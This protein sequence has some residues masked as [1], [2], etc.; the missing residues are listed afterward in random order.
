MTPSPR[1]DRTSR[2]QVAGL[3]LCV[4]CAAVAALPA[5]AHAAPPANDAFADAQ[6]VRV[7]DR[8]TG[9]TTDA[10]LQA[11]EPATGASYTR[12]VWYRLTPTTSEMLRI[13][14][15][16]GGPWAEL[17]VFTGTGVA[18]L[19]EVTPVRH[20][21]S[22]GS[23]LYID[24]VAATTYYVRV[25]GFDTFAGGLVLDVARPQAPANDNF[26]NA[27]PIG[28]PAHITGSNVDA[29][30]QPGEPEPAMYGGSGHSV[31]YKLAATTSDVVSASTVA[32]PFGA[33]VAVYTGDAVN[34]LTEVGREG[35]PTGQRTTMIFA[36]APGTTY[37]IAVRGHG[38]GA[39][40]FRLDVSAPEP[41]SSPPDVPIPPAPPCGLTSDPTL[42]IYSGTHS[43]GGEVCLRITK[44]GTGVAWFHGTNVPGDRCTIPWFSE[45]MYSLPA[46]IDS[47]RWSFGSPFTRL[48]GSFPSNRGARG[49]L[50]VTQRP[51]GGRACHSAPIAWTATTTGT[52]PWADFTPP[53]LRLGGVT[54]QRPLRGR[55]A[56]VVL[57]R[58]RGE[59]C[60]VS[61][62][63]TVAGV[64]VT[65]AR[66]TVKTSSAGRAVRLV[67]PARARRA[68]AAA[69]RSRP[70]VRTQITVV[71]RDEAGNRAT[72]RRTITLRR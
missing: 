15:C 52:P 36:T 39:G 32:G 70:S 50:Q 60:G 64:K 18:D 14:T 8:I 31:W 34:R 61:A 20:G 58:C 45:V 68:L 33:M 5:A 24:A 46:P 69:L 3:V 28:R 23:R 22:A 9:T 66:R 35:G 63:A 72:A 26:E 12:S 19:T 59:S 55:R 2:L 51:A 29:T 30:V 49:T 37:Y 6:V 54:V 47:R 4:L 38:D 56:L 10:T 11:G 62:S 25:T 17:A 27:Q 42:I 71:A 16:S 1:P 21:C 57:V 43:A 7:G 41:P 53:A 13:D 40:E 65:A 67:L 48:I 44:D